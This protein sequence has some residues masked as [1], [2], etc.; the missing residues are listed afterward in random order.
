MKEREL[1]ELLRASKYSFAGKWPHRYKVYEL[2]SKENKRLKEQIGKDGFFDYHVTNKGYLVGEHQIVAYY[3]SGGI[4]HMRRG[5]VAKKGELEVHHL[6]GKTVDN[7]PANLRYV[8][9]RMHEVITKH[10]RCINKFLKVFTKSGL[11]YYA[12]DQIEVPT[13]KGRVVKDKVS[14]LAGLIF[15]TM[16][17][18][19]EVSFLGSIGMLKEWYKKVLKRLER[20]LDST[21]IP[22]PPAFR[23]VEDG[24]YETIPT[25]TPSH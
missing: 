1:K 4:H 9:V 23:K 7:K 12:G 21:Y 24:F 25:C 22:T 2:G 20:G 3:F 18:T 13:R 14:Y 17:K 6:N 15:L 11:N 5:G 19:S 16:V 8:S 10:Q